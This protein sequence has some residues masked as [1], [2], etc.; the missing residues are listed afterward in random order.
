MSDPVPLT[1]GLFFVALVLA[2]PLIMGACLLGLK[3]VLGIIALVGLA[4]G[5]VAFSMAVAFGVP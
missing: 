1:D 3:E 2:P 5:W 4:V